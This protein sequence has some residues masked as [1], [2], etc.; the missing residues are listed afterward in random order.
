FNTRE[1][2]YYVG[3]YPDP[4]H[5]GYNTMSDSDKHRFMMWYDTVREKTFDFQTEIR[6]YCVNDVE[7][8]RKAC[9][10][11]RETFIRCTDLD[12]F[13]FTTLASSCMGVFKTHFLPKNTLA[14]TYEGA[15]TRQNKTYSEVSMQW[16]EYVAKVEGSKI[17]H[18]LNHGE[19][20]FGQFFYG[21]V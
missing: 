19:Q 15:Y 10:I 7:V 4:S 14:L 16:L 13:A 2:E 11:Y 9:L 17:R 6:H 3:K 20:R 21:W 12:P 5:Y 1:N 18:A 8:L